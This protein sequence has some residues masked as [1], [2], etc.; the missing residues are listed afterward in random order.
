MVSLLPSQRLR[1]LPD[2]RNLGCHRDDLY[3]WS[4]QVSPVRLPRC[5]R[6]QGFGD[7]EQRSYRRLRRKPPRYFLQYQGMVSANWAFSKLASGDFSDAK[8]AYVREGNWG[9]IQSG[10]YV[11]KGSSR[12]VWA[13]ALLNSGEA[14]YQ[15]AKATGQTV[16]YLVR[17]PVTGA[18]EVAAAPVVLVGGT[19][20]STT[21]SGVTTGWALP[22]TA[23][24]D[25]VKYVGEGVWPK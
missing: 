13:V 16:Y 22:V 11:L 2:P 21:A 17:Y 9:I 14:L 25:G 19:A 23:T 10:Y 24:L 6:H 12:V 8:E 5:S 3:R 1:R 7:C 4:T 15:I 20:W 18:V